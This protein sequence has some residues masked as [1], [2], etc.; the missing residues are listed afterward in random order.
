MTERTNSPPAQDADREALFGRD[1]T[2]R[3]VAVHPVETDGGARMKLYRRT[4]ED[5][6]VTEEDAF[7]PFL[8]LSD[9][10][11]LKGFGRDRFRFQELSGPNYYRYLAV[12]ESWNAHWQAYRH[13]R[14]RAGGEDGS[15]PDE[16]YLVPSPSQQYLMQT[17]RT[18]FKEMG[19][20][21]LH[22]MQLD[23]E[24]FTSEEFPHAD[25]AED[26]IIAVGLSDNRGWERVIDLQDRTEEAL[27]EKLVGVIRDR[28]P[29]VLEGHNCFSF[30]FDYLRTRC[31]RHGVSFAIGRDGST[32]RTFDSTVRFAER[33]I[34]F[35]GLDVA[36]R[37]VVD[38]YFLVLSYDVFKRDL[39]GYGL[40]EAARYFG[41]SSDG[42]TYL[43]GD[44][45]SA[46]WE[47]DPDR[48]RAYVLDDV[49][50]TERLARHLSG[51]PFYLTQMLP[52]PYEQVARSGPAGKIESLFVREYL[53]RKAALPESE[54]GSQS[55]GGYTDVFI[56]GVV[57]P[58]VYADVDSLYPSIMLHYEVRPDGD[59]LDLFPAFLELLTNLRSRTKTEMQEAEDP[60]AR[61]ELDARQ[62]SYKILINSFYGMLGFGRALFNDVSEADRV[63]RTGQQILRKILRLIEEKGGRVVEADTDGVLFVPPEE[64]RGR[65]AE[66]AFLDT[67]NE[68][69]P[70]GIHIGFDGRYRRMLSY[71]KKNYALLGYDG[72]LTFKGSSLISRSN[73]QFGRAFVRRAARLLMDGDV[74][75]LHELYLE[76]RDRIVESRWEVE[77]FARTETLKDTVEAY[78]RA[79][80]QGNRPRAAS[81]ELAIQR[82]ERTGQPVRKGDRITYYI[83]GDD[84]NARGYENA[85]LASEWDPEDPDENTAYYLKRL[86]QFTRKFEPFFTDHDFRLIFSPEDLFGFEASGIEIQTIEHA[87]RLEEEVD[88]EEELPF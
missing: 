11:L 17:G 77:E 10:R 9:V 87:G 74:E 42:R 76:T 60:E 16:V 2:A 19:F 61:S 40:K 63:A 21:E 66:D 57:G 79:V 23:I 20:E 3:I 47:A 56:T 33:T 50:E 32:P 70:E 75:D 64:V 52:M 80:D 48:V 44:R 1:P 12:F 37:H 59:H 27:L 78:R 25:R 18:L 6:L 85:Q 26:R 28:D 72:E 39:P 71:K 36:G 43:E 8:F 29:D 41:L 54:W 45:I 69:M 38:T 35:P 62:N 7:Y 84:P 53:H 73:E 81:Y 22:R 46:T 58:V 67:L 86:E 88:A 51:S 30:D 65:E 83:T 68:E 13:V 49:R 82:A 55:M 34:D 4:E 5:E 14:D 24:V 15:V 31:R